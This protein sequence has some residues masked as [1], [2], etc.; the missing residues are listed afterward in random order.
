MKCCWPS[1]TKRGVWHVRNTWNGVVVFIVCDLHLH[2]LT[3]A[4]PPG[5]VEVGIIESKEE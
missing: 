5:K 1:C 4:F 2:R 3:D